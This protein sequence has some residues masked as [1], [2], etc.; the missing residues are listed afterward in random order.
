LS[1]WTRCTGLVFSACA[2]ILP[3][4]ASDI[5]PN[6]AVRLPIADVTDRIFVPIAVEKELSHAW[7]GQIVEDNQGFIWLG[8][9]DILVRYDGS[10]TKS[11]SPGSAGSTG[12]FVQECCRYTLFRDRSGFIWIGASDSVY[13]YDSVTEQ[14]KMLPIAPDKLQGL[15]R[16]INEDSAGIMW[17]A[18]SRGLTRYNPR[19][20]ESARLVH[21][22]ADPATLG[23]NF[24]RATLEARDGTF[25]V[26]T[27]TTV[28][29]FDRKTGRVTHHFSLRNPLQ[30]PDSTGNPY[31]RLLE[32]RK[33]RVW[34]ASARDGLAFIGPERK[35][36]AFVS[37]AAGR[38]I[39]PGAWAILE[40]RKGALWV[41]TE[42]G[43]IRLDLD[44]KQL[45]RYRNDP[46]DHD[47]LPADWVLA[48]FEDNEDGIWAGT[49]NG[50]VARFSSDP[51]PFR[52]YR[53]PQGTSSSSDY[54]V[55]AFEDSHGVI[56]AGTKGAVNR[57]DLKTGRYDVQSI[58]ENTEVGSI[59]ED[60]SGQFWI[61]TFDGSLFRSSP[62]APASVAYPHHAGAP[63]C[64]NNEVRALLVDHDGTLW[65][66]A[67]DS[68]CS[69]DPA[70]NQFRRYQTGIPPPAE[71][72]ALAEDESGTFWIGSRQAGLYRFDPRTVSFKAY[73]HSAAPDSLS[74]DGVTSILVARSGT[75]WAGT[76]RGLDR[77]DPQ[78]GKFRT[79][80]TRDGLP[81]DFVNGIA[82]DESGSLWVTTSY[83]LSHFR[84]TCKNGGS[85]CAYELNKEL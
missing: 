35:A 8:T 24:V 4:S 85:V 68:L 73:R 55:F 34:I 40:D 83:G 41:G 20:G 30:K 3:I 32:D 69:F 33:G 77:L 65:A 66:G 18:T 10:Q 78:T 28:D 31:V 14:F 64:A 58:G 44:R 80:V 27:N 61:G 2:V 46:T 56:W 74:D 38:N 48:L 37:L 13:K 39:E 6:Q 53:R 45:L 54:V 60:R 50:G 15:V 23:S 26:A 42:Y 1:W 79:Y 76:V 47:S 25:W 7:V 62:G 81:N 17:L 67:G 84:G 70:T 36:L 51:P 21:D 52:R 19:N 63:G 11:F 12:V 49:A 82:E 72:D 57:I 9:R 71:I 43:L 59:A 16:G 5:A 29:I 75:I 22:E